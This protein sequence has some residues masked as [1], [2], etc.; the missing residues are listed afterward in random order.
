MFV[1]FQAN[2]SSSFFT[3][4]NWG[5]KAVSFVIAIIQAVIIAYLT[6]L[7]LDRAFSATRAVGRK[8]KKQGITRV[9]DKGTMSLSETDRLFGVHGDSPVELKLFFLTGNEFFYSFEEKLKYISKLAKENCTIKILLCNPNRCKTAALWGNTDFST[10]APKAVP[11]VV[12]SYYSERFSTNGKFDSFLERHFS[13]SKHN[14][15]G[16]NPIADKTRNF[17][18]T[19]GDYF[20]QINY[21]IHILSTIENNLLKNIHVRFFDDEFTHSFLLAKFQRPNNQASMFAHTTLN[22]PIK[23]AVESVSITLEKNDGEDATYYDDLDETFNYLWGKYSDTEIQWD[24]ILTTD[25][26]D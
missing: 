20:Y 23:D 1:L 26:L 25:K 4:I 11:D 5:D 9:S 19:H 12:V 7:A 2:Q 22:A 10:R 18:A 6:K 24:S 8:L 17:L 16:N 13:L 21:A 14:K 3:N 15:L